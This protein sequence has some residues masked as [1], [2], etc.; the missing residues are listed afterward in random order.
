VGGTGTLARP[1]MLRLP[2]QLGS[3]V[4]MSFEYRA[5]SSLAARFCMVGYAAGRRWLPDARGRA[6]ADDDVVHLCST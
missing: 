3:Y 2:L 5:C 4:D 6:G 1:G